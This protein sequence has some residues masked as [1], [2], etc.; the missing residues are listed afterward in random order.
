[1][2]ALEQCI[3]RDIFYAAEALSARL[4]ESQGKA[5][6]H[7]AKVVVEEASHAD[8]PPV[9]GNN[10]FE[11]TVTFLELLG[12]HAYDLVDSVGDDEGNVVRKLVNIHENKVCD[13]E[14]CEVSEVD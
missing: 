1:M 8:D 2:E 14:Q 3:A 7:D 6:S 9:K 10:V 12:K 13:S 11:L 5:P 4:L